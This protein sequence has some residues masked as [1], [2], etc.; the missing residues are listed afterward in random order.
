MSEGKRKKEALP[1][2]SPLPTTRLVPV[3]GLSNSHLR[4][5]VPG[6]QHL[7]ACNTPVLLLS[8]ASC[9]RE[10]PFASSANWNICSSSQ[11][12]MHLQPVIGLG[13]LRKSE[14]KRKALMLC[15]QFLATAKTLLYYHHWFCHKIQSIV[16]CKLLWKKLTP[17]QPNPVQLHCGLGDLEAVNKNWLLFCW[18]HEHYPF[19][20]LYYS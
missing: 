11:P 12:L 10:Y 9:G 20:V 8:I 6:P 13:K 16:P 3:Q 14:G 7:L 19:V 15:K 18:F 17:S 5:N 2:Q 1:R 4:V